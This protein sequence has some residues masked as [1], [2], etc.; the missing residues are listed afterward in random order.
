[1]PS[2][3]ARYACTP[4]TGPPLASEAVALRNTDVSGSVSGMGRCARKARRKGR[5]GVP[6]AWATGVGE[7]V[8]SVVLYRE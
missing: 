5:I 3:A 7:A 8:W 1:M 2:F 4:A 6:L